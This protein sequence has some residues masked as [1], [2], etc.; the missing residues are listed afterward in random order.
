MQAFFVQKTPQKFPRVIFRTRKPLRNSPASFSGPKNLAKIPPRRFQD[1]KTSQKFPCV[2]F[3][4]RKPFR[5]PPARVPLARGFTHQ[6]SSKT[7]AAQSDRQCHPCVDPH[8]R[9]IAPSQRPI[10]RPMLGHCHSCRHQKQRAYRRR[11]RLALCHP[12]SMT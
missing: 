5:N 2:I 4:T 3:E 9:A 11:A 6:C 10:H 12:L 8:L 7:P 1:Q